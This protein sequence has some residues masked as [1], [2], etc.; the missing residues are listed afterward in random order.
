M[1]D[2]PTGTRLIQVGHYAKEAVIVPRLTAVESIPYER[3]ME[4]T[5]EEIAIVEGRDH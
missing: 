4:A 3:H 5:E 2:W 1:G